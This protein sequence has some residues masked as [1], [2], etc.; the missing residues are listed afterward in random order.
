M[1]FGFLWKFNVVMGF[2][3]SKVIE[4]NKKVNGLKRKRSEK[5]DPLKTST[6]SL[7]MIVRI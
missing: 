7:L 1:G 3:W 5:S 4:K 6:L 2:M